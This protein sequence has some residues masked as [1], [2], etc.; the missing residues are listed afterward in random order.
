M[1]IEFHDFDQIFN[2]DTFNRLQSLF[3]RLSETHVLCHLHANN[4]VG[5]TSVGGFTIPPVFEATYIQ[6]R[7]GEGRLAP[8]ADTA[9]LGPT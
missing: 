3:A 6:T 5:Y 1:L 9:P 8:C 2:A 4:T 7:P